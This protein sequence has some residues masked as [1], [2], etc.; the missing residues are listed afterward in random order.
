MRIA[1]ILALALPAL[2]ALAQ[3]TT[4]SY[5]YDLNGRPVVAGVDVATKSD[6]TTTR[7]E[8]GVSVNGRTVPRQSVEEKTL[9]SDAN[10][11][12]V[13]RLVTEYNPN[14]QPGLPEKV[15]IDT[16]TNSDGSKTIQTSVYRGDINGAMHLD[17]QTTTERR[18][19]GQTIDTTSVVSRP[20]INGGL[21]TVEKRQSVQQLRPDG[22]HESTDVYRKDDN[23]DFY[24]ARR[25]ITDQTKK[26][27][28][29]TENTAVY[30]P[31]A[32]GPMQLTSQTVRT[33]M[34]EADG[35]EHIQVDIYG[36]NVPGTVRDPDAKLELK[37][38]QLI[39]RTPG[40][41][42]KVVETLGVRRPTIS[43]PTTLG[44]ARK[45]SETVCTGKCED[46]AAQP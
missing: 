41:G 46:P 17:E 44:S 9:R 4:T 14:G 40:N 32:N 8:E 26:N 19:Q 37:E 11:T 3:N 2:T 36:R 6:G 27:G 18:E 22:M 20:S 43:D 15:L 21:A 38:Q 16:Q 7:T 42:N 1:F 10:H 25:Q 34:K 33:T 13:E 24:Q 39:D 30:E 35:S 28:T 31:G 23:G 5:T 12:V 45:L 29:V